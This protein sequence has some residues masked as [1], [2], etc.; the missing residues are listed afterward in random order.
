MKIRF[1]G[2]E[3]GSMISQKWEK[4][5]VLFWIAYPQL[6]E[7]N[8]IILLARFNS[9]FFTTFFCAKLLICSAEK[10]MQNKIRSVSIRMLLCFLYWKEMWL[11]A[12]LQIYYCKILD[13]VHFL[14]FISNNT[15]AA[16][17]HIASV[18]SKFA[19]E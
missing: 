1:F 17:F 8:D 15:K 11:H 16:A 12:I 6:R 10:S 7:R 3:H 4:M 14:W 18:L 2:I 9:S 19:W 13:R 5:W